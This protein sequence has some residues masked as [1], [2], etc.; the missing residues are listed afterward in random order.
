MKQLE[1]DRLIL[2]SWRDSDFDPM[3]IIDQDANVC[4][5][6]PKIGDRESTATMIQRIIKHDI[7]HG[8]SLYAVELKAT[9]EMIGFIGLI[10]PSFD[11]HF[12]PAVEIGWRLASHHW[13]EGYATE[14]AKAVLHHAFVDLNLERVVSFTVVDNQR[15][16]RV[17]EKIGLHHN[18]EDDF[19]H[20]KLAQDSPLKRHVLYQVSKADY[21]KKL[22]SL[23]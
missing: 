17:M 15:S 7:E 18:R 20:P 14:G 6:L 12:T 16:R 13:N 3:A 19:D 4:E 8:F 11:A 10:S 22:V 21:L 2:R 5:F 9:H 23:A 1:T